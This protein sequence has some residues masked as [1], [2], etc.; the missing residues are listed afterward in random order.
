MELNTAKHNDN[1]GYYTSYEFFSV[2][3]R[4][5]FQENDV[6]GDQVSF[7]YFWVQIAVA[8]FFSLNCRLK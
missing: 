2:T 5:E 4:L 3:Q 8:I 6:S 7:F 1:I